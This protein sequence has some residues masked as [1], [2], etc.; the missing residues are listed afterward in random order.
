MNE[1]HSPALEICAQ[2]EERILEVQRL[3]LEP[4]TESL[5]YIRAE[6]AE[7]IGGLRQIGKAR[8]IDPA[9]RGPLQRLGSSTRTLA[10]QIEHGANL[11]MGFVQLR[12]ASGYTRQGLPSVHHSARNSVEA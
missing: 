11:Y 4:S 5:D 2:A 10:R 8:P 3:L 1:A 9:L 12:L 7:V 6:L